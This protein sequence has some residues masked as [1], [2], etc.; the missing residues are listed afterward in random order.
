[1]KILEMI[2]TIGPGGAETLVADLSKEFSR[3]GNQVKL[4]LLAGVKGTRGRLLKD[5]LEESGVEIIGL[6]ERKPSNLNN[7]LLVNKVLKSYRP[8]IVHCHLYSS[9]VVFTIAQLFL[10]GKRPVSIRTLHNSKIFGT[11]NLTIAKFLYK[12]FDW[13]VACS[14][15]VYT[16]FKNY[17][18]FNQV[19]K[20]LTIL[21]G[22]FLANSIT[23]RNQKQSARKLL[24]LDSK[25]N[26][27]VNIAG[28]RGERLE[29]SQKAQDIILR[30]YAIAFRNRDDTI[31][32][33]AGDGPLRYEA[34]KLSAELGLRHKVQFIGNIVE[35][36][37]LLSAAD[38]FVMAS[39]YEGLP[40]T[41]LEAGSVGL[42]V[43]AT[44]ILEI[45]NICKGK[46]WLLIPV[47]DV[48]ALANALNTAF[49]YHSNDNYSVIETAKIIRKK[50]S[51]SK[52]ANGYMNLFKKA[53]EQKAKYN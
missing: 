21:N 15:A 46:G 6:E 14:D 18:K 38:L 31:L 39:R 8:D 25:K 37:S 13:T 17:L 42:P 45:K 34:E 48:K 50:Y 4:L 26:I 22:C 24:H 16:S 53:Y 27:I 43:V 19:S 11:N 20:L 51:L 3:A 33:L 52:C 36:W 5:Q 30:A 2:A 40:L 12:T 10:K 29:T 1:M 47:D 28:F 23:T 44:N 35:P 9:E 32:I 49:R 41:L 7:L